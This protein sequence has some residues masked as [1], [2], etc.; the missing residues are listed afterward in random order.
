L[1]HY[2]VNHFE[3]LIIL[4]NFSILVDPGSSRYFYAH[5]I[6]FK[7]NI[8][9]LE[10]VAT[11]DR[12]LEYLKNRRDTFFAFDVLPMKIE[13]G[14]GAPCRLVARLENSENRSG[15]WFGF[16]IFFL[17]VGVIGIVAKAIYDFKFNPD[18]NFG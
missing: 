11:L 17:L 3:R 9:A 8:Y 6:L 7:Q 1:I 2:Q 16:L 10:N 4:L 14:T 15:G 12:V 18:K 13:G 5:R